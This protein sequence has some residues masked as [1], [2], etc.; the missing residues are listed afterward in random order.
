MRNVHHC[1]P[2]RLLCLGSIDREKIIRLLLE[3]PRTDIDAFGDS[4]NKTSA[5][6]DFIDNISKYKDQAYYTIVADIIKLFL[7]RNA[8]TKGKC[9]IDLDAFDLF[10]RFRYIK[11]D[12]KSFIELFL[13]YGKVTDQTIQRNRK[14]MNTEELKIINDWMIPDV[15]QPE[16]E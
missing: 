1:T 13:E 12:D 5:L 4:W 6:F 7:Q 14:Y 11:F 8:S 3:D 2:L 10:T 16:H 15:K 9:I